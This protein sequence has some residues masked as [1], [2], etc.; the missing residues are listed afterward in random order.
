MKQLLRKKFSD[1]R[2]GLTDEVYHSFS[3][4]IC[5]SFLASDAYKSSSVIHC[6]ISMNRRK[7]VNT[8]PLL[9]FML[10]DA[11][12]I[13]VPIMLPDG[14]LKHV[15]INT[16]NDLAENSWGVLEPAKGLEVNS[17]IADC[18]IVPM[19]AG[20]INR[21][22][23]GYGKGYYDRFL[24]TT[25]AT[26]IGFCFDFAILEALPVEKHD[27]KLTQIITEKRIISVSYP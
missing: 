10:D 21:N 14:K 16:L 6:Y 19:L 8:L 13:I 11:K 3:N 7:E 2:L 23:L 15:Q 1:E 18:I 12:H 5:S 9:Q 17:E 25:N 24:Q 4:K 20:D 26:K 22:R 27:E